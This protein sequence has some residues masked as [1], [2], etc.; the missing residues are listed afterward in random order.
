MSV[1]TLQI[2]SGSGR[3]ESHQATPGPPVYL[4]SHESNRIRLL[5]PDIAPRHLELIY[6]QGE[7]QWYLK[8]LSPLGRPTLNGYFLPPDDRRP[9][10]R[11]SLVRVGDHELRF[12][13]PPTTR[14]EPSAV[15]STVPAAGPP[16]P[17]VPIRSPSITPLPAQWV[18]AAVTRSPQDDIV[19]GE[20]TT[21]EL[22]L[23]NNGPQL[24][25]FEIE[26]VNRELQYKLKTPAE[27]RV[28]AGE[29]RPV[30]LTFIP[31]RSPGTRAGDY[32]LTFRVTESKH[33]SGH[34]DCTVLITILPFYEFEIDQPPFPL[35]KKVGWHVDEVSFNFDLKNLGNAP[36]KFRLAGQDLAQECTFGFVKKSSGEYLP[37]GAITMLEAG[38]PV[39]FQARIKP[40]SYPIFLRKKTYPF[41]LSVTA[42][43]GRQETKTL[44]GKIVQRPLIGW[45]WP[46]LILLL[47]LPVCAW[48][49]LWPRIFIFKADG[50]V[51]GVSK[52]ENEPLTLEWRAWPPGVDLRLE[53]GIGPIS[54][55]PFG[56][57]QVTVVPGQVYGIE[58]ETFTCVL[59][60]GLLG[61]SCVVTKTLN[62]PVTPIAPQVEPLRVSSDHVI[63]G[64]A[65]EVAVRVDIRDA[66]VAGLWVNQT[67]YPLATDEY[68]SEK[69]FK[70]AQDTSI[71]AVA[72][73]H[74]FTVTQEIFI[75]AV[76]PTPSPTPVPELGK[77]N[78]SDTQV[79]AGE[80][81]T[82]DY[83]A[84]GVE[85][86]ILLPD[87]VRYPAS[88]TI[89]LNPDGS[90]NY[91]LVAVDDQGNQTVLASQQVIVESPTG[92]PTPTATPAA[93]N[94]A[95][96]KTLS[97]RVVTGDDE[98]DVV[99]LS[100]IIE[101]EVTNV[102][103]LNK[104]GLSLANNLPPTSQYQVLVD[105]DSNLFVLV[106]YNGQQSDRRNVSIAVEEAV[107]IQFFKAEFVNNQNNVIETCYTSPK[108]HEEGYKQCQ[109]ISGTN[110]IWLKWDVEGTTDIELKQDL[111]GSDNIY[112]GV[113]PEDSY[114]LPD[115]NTEAN[116][117]GKYTLIAK[118]K[119]GELKRRIQFKCDDNVNLDKFC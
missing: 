39:E 88:G 1:I 3:F 52:Q 60:N 21:F 22:T 25:E 33:Y 110:K 70:I 23:T 58:A 43:E 72:Q 51:S 71:I 45:L 57:R 38:G 41:T 63:Q 55:E 93:P 18:A 2:Y 115:N 84:E 113:G 34:C 76:T 12:F 26:I 108:D 114:Q 31:E 74:S 61:R 16:A 102:E 53:P 10:G 44:S 17:A 42:Q 24:A 11:A 98:D 106:A 101:G 105:E 75:P 69:T 119:S 85:E 107:I 4:G 56:A 116:N 103:L 20:R 27:I 91:S 96:F 29:I 6:N 81:L 78:F 28:N 62:I 30:S 32:D 112:H 83:A 79:T 97:G 59:V 5:G 14:P 37:N 68:R 89:P 86:V 49:M 35:S 73:R 65:E 94:I 54:N 48:L 47:L 80:P 117:R 109:V 8:A 46:V 67:P 66:Q 87:G 118:G 82:I 64:E 15:V 99:T 100:W 90:T 7:G 9:L 104:Q 111:K 92:T 77:L 50:Q 36:A 40:E 95:E 13:Q 19:P